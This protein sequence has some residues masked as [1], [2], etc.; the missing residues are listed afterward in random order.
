MLPPIETMNWM[1]CVL[2]TPWIAW[3]L[4]FGKF[5][6]HQIKKGSMASFLILSPRV[7]EA[8]GNTTALSLYLYTGPPLF[9]SC[10]Q[11]RGCDNSLEWH[12]I[13]LSPVLHLFLSS[14]IGKTMISCWW[15]R[16]FR[17]CFLFHPSSGSVS[18]EW[19]LESSGLSRWHHLGRLEGQDTSSLLGKVGAE[20]EEGTRQVTWTET[21]SLGWRHYRKCPRRMGFWVLDTLF[22]WET[23]PA[24]TG[25]GKCA[26]FWQ[27]AK[28]KAEA[29]CYVHGLH[30]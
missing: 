1:C 3:L 24:H 26:Q 12:C 2:S 16:P 8:A 22:T 10:T 5:R 28:R 4:R 29:A 23:P 18:G 17:C 30:I 25:K 7:T 27:T 14:G 6:A 11:S 13:L 15:G 19:G 9:L 20:L 21:E